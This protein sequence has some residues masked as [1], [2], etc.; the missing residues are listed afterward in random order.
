MSVCRGLEWQVLLL[1]NV[2]LQSQRHVPKRRVEKYTSNERE[3]R[4]EKPCKMMAAQSTENRYALNS[5][6][7]HNGTGNASKLISLLCVARAKYTTMKAQLSAWGQSECP[8]PWF[9]TEDNSRVAAVEN[10]G[11]IADFIVAHKQ[12]LILCLWFNVCV[13]IIRIYLLISIIV[14]YFHISW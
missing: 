11:R 1:L 10:R 12:L 7:E 6:N 5:W 14:F 8:Y 13:H 9:P 3:Q 4:Q 2:D